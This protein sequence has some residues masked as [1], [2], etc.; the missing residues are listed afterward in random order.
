[1]VIRGSLVTISISDLAQVSLATRAE[2]GPADR[3]F[4][5]CLVDALFSETG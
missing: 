4:A 5:T 2:N 3:L 1:M